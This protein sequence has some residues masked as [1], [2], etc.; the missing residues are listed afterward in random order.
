MFINISNHP[1]TRWSAEQLAAAKNL[2]GN[3]IDIALPNVPPTAS[4]ED[5]GGMAKAIAEDAIGSV[6]LGE[7][8][9][10]MVAGP[11]GFCRAAV[12]VLEKAGITCV[13]ACSERSTSEQVL[14]D[15]STRKVVTFQFIQ[16][17]KV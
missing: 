14:P 4:T 15:G 16:F 11:L 13:E 10:A 12:K 17:R 6:P 2:G 5:V 3:V 7:S 8:A 9:T 1:S